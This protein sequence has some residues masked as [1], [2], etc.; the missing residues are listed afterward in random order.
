MDCYKS[1]WESEIRRFFSQLK[2]GNYIKLEDC[3]AV[4]YDNKTEKSNDPRYIVY[5]FRDNRLCDDHFC[6]QHSRALTKAEMKKI[7]SVLDDEG[8]DYTDWDIY[9]EVCGY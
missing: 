5:D 3:L 1:Q 6:S 4:A 9:Y 8:V 7:F 2:K